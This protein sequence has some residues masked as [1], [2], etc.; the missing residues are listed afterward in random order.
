MRK[1]LV[2]TGLIIALL[3]ACIMPLADWLTQLQGDL[4]ANDAAHVIEP[5]MRLYQASAVHCADVPVDPAVEIERIWE[6]EDMREEAETP[7]VSGMRNG[8]HV[9]GYDAPSQT[10]Y[11]T[12]GLTF[13]NDAWPELDLYVQ[14]AD[15]EIPVKAMFVDDYT[16][17][18]P[19]DSVADGYRYELLAYTE[20]EYQYFGLVFTG[21]PI[22]TIHSE[23]TIGDEY[24]PVCVSVSSAQ[25]EAIT[26]MAKAHL[27]GGGYDKGIDKQNYR[28]EFHQITDAGKDKRKDV[29]VLGFEPDSDWLLIANAGDVSGMR[30]ELGF[31]MWRRWN[32]GDEAFMLLGSEVVEVFVQDSY[33]GMYQLMQRIDEEKELTQMGGNLATD[34]TARMIGPRFYTGKPFTEMSMPLGGCMELRYA[35]AWASTEAAFR[36]F[37]NY[38][39][40]NLS[41]G[42]EGYLDD[43][44]FAELALRSVNVEELMSYF[45]FMNVCSLPMD[46]VK[47]NVFIWA[48]KNEDG[49]VYTLSPWDMD[50]GFDKLFTDGTDSMNLWM[51]LPVRMLN[52]DIGGSREALWRLWQEK[53]QKLLTED[54]VYQWIQE[55]EEMINASR[56]YRRDR[57]YWWG[58]DI[59]LDLSEIAAQM[60][61]RRSIIEEYMKEVWPIEDLALMGLE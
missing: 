17:D 13:E 31:D 4:E 14:S 11:C 27:R 52:L 58:E 53:Q 51:M 43:E 40:L 7:L 5:M 55:K 2:H 30:N 29:S 56:A 16:Y 49:F 45:L 57:E 36:V 23:Q 54:A 6:I 8:D 12:V 47:N 18:Y 50:W 9:L 42:Q 59:D 22:V 44:A 10:F 39:T 26:S 60:I 3:L 48:M 25:D 24:L 28:V 34:M 41:E 15:E 19:Q 20:N 1:K 37:E 46:N 32:E 33:S 38:V 61:L 21:L 35:P